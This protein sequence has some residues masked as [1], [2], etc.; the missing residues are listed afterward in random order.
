MQL[1]VTHNDQ[2]AQLTQAELY[3]ALNDSGLP[4]FIC[5]DDIF[6]VGEQDALVL[7]TKYIAGA[8]SDH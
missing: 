5:S 6:V 4:W 2:H 7:H 8:Y 1:L 3:E